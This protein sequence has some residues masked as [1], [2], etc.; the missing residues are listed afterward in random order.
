MATGPNQTGSTLQSP[1]SSALGYGSALMEQVSDEEK[2]RRKKV[3]DMGSQQ[4]QP[5]PSL[6]QYLGYPSA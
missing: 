4:E 6:S 2:A 3:Q 5:M 1:V